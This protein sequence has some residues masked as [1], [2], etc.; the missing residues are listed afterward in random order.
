MIGVCVSLVAKA[1]ANSSQNFRF[2]FKVTPTQFLVG[3]KALITE[4][5]FSKNYSS[6]LKLGW[7]KGPR[8]EYSLWDSRNTYASGFISQ[9]GI[10]KYISFSAIE[11]QNLYRLMYV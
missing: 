6:E 8:K 11:Y 9:V 3:E 4:F 10:K 1:Q 5:K 7:F 2:G